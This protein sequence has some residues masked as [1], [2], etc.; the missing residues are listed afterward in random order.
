MQPHGWGITLQNTLCTQD[1]KSS[2]WFQYPHFFYPL[3]CPLHL[4]ILISLEFFIC[5]EIGHVIVWG[6]L[7]T[8]GNLF[9][10]FL[11]LTYLVLVIWQ[12]INICIYSA[13]INKPE[14]PNAQQFYH[15]DDSYGRVLASY[16]LGFQYKYFLQ[17]SYNK[18]IVK[19]TNNFCSLR[20]FNIFNLIQKTLQP[21]YKN[22]KLQNHKKIVA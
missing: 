9:L 18:T 21:N 20:V 4:H 10:L 7:G 13:V 5:K 12:C 16:K 2:F 1:K 15:F 6:T 22:L 19:V 11:G 3:Q 8:R 17:S 14:N